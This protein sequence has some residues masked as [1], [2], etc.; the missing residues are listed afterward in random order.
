MTQRLTIPGRLPGYN[1]L[2]TGHWARRNRV[3][4]EALE[5]VGWEI[6]RQR[7]MPVCGRAT[8]RIVCYEPNR[9]R[10]PSNVRAGAEKV[11]LDALQECGIIRGDGWAW[12]DDVPAAVTVDRRAE[13]VEVRIEDANQETQD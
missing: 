10:D 8:V 9:K 3:K 1:Q 5:L 12:L 13:R 6:R 4:R 11:I 7:I 2:T